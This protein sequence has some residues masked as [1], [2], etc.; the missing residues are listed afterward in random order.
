L[1]LGREALSDSLELCLGLRTV[2]SS[3]LRYNGHTLCKNATCREPNNGLFVP[4]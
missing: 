4:Y 3:S 2:S 1:G